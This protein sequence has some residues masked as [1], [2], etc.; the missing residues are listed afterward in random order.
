[1]QTVRIDEAAVRLRELVHSASAGEDVLIT[2]DDRAVA[3]IT[4]P[5]APQGTL[6]DIRPVSVG[7]VLQPLSPEDDLLEEM[8]GA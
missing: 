1:M 7:A 8:S 6:R 3:R 2:E 5:V 4:A